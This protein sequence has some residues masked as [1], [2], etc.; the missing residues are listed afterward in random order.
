MSKKYL[1]KILARDLNGLNLI[2]LYCYKSKLK[3][4]DIKFLKKNKI[5]LLEDCSQSIGAELK[6]K[7]VGT[8]GDISAFSTMYRKNLAANSSSGL[9]F[10]K[11]KKLY[12]KILAYADRGKILWKKN[13]DLRDKTHFFWMSPLQ[14]DNVI[15]FHP[16]LIHKNHSCGFG[17]TYNHLKKILPN[18]TEITRFFSYQHWLDFYQIGVE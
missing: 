8:F 12:R 3:T 2:S 17:R 11:N 7:K 4:S 18:D 16:Y 1:A 6:K 10:T 13:L 9:V 5:F 14:F 15:E